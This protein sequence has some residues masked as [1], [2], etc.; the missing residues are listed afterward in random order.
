[1]SE[2]VMIIGYPASG[3][4]TIAKEYFRK[5]YTYLNRDAV[6]GVILD[7]IPHLMKALKNSENVI[8]DNTFPTVESRKAF[9]ECATLPDATY[10]A[11]I[12]CEWV[13]TSI[14][15]AQFN[16]CCR[17]MERTGKILSPDEMKANKS[18]NLFPPVVLFK[19]KKELQRPTIAE[20]IA[21]SNPVRGDLIL[22]AVRETKGSVVAVSETDILKGQETLGRMGLYVEPTSA[23][24]VPALK[25]LLD[26]GELARSETV[27]MPLTGTGLKK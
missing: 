11:T 13:T 22:E 1:M 9:I 5:G 21:L 25:K 12:T 7:L 17:M 24:V 6:G 20:G 27:V 16:A 18:P 26:D 3:K 15:D 23:V 2:V 10:Q 4:S 19:Y 14:E 8:L